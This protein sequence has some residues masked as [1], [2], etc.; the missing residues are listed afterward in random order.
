MGQGISI[1]DKKQVII[2]NDAHQQTLEATYEKDSTELD[3]TV[4]VHTEPKSNITLNY[5]SAIL[6]GKWLTEQGEAIKKII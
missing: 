1:T 4:Q 3:I 2:S 5:E 6:L